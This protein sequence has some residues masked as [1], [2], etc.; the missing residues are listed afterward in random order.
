LL[1]TDD[2]GHFTLP[3][4]D[5]ISRV[6]VASPSGYAETT[7]ADLKNSPT[8]TLQ[9]WGRIEGTC[10][11][12]GQPV[13][14]REYLFGLNDSTDD[15]NSF[16]ADFTVFRV[17]SDEQ[18]KFTMPMV[19]PG[20]HSLVRLIPQSMG[21]NQKSWMHGDKTEVDIQPGA[22][23]TVTLGN[24][25]YTVTANLQ[26]PDG[27]PPTNLMNVMIALHTPMPPLSPEIAGHQD[28]IQQYYRSP[29]FQ[30]IAKTAHSYPMALNADGTLAA[31]DVPSGNYK[32]Y[33][34]AILQPQGG[35]PAGS[36]SA[37]E[38]SVTVPSDPPVGQLN[39][40]TIE[41][42]ETPAH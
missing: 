1:R 39:A 37:P 16:S 4:D 41:L 35:K 11:S 24:K 14:G 18:G 38:I 25:G 29:E 9:S 12:G 7:P 30:A 42:Q 40:G 27:A 23:A 15:D 10:F 36:M 32:L 5:T 21:A 33:A 8:I 22:T 26:W 13:A 20:K 28:L 6:I 19:P 34:F 2:A 31:D 17:T 3:S